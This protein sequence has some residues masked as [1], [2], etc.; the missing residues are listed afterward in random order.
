M[1]GLAHVEAKCNPVSYP[2][3][4]IRLLQRVK[5]RTHAYSFQY[6]LSGDLIIL[7]ICVAMLARWQPADNLR[8]HYTRAVSGSSL[9]L[10]SASVEAVLREDALSRAL[11]TQ[12]IMRR[13][14]PAVKSADPALPNTIL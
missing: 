5:R 10:R 3:L 6:S 7:V 1:P 2:I 14:R 12:G 11:F 4:H 8:R 13:A 9:S